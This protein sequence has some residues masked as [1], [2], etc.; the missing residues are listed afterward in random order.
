MAVF[1]VGSML[2]QDPETGCMGIGV[3]LESCKQSF[4]LKQQNQILKQGTQQQS[5]ISSA[6]DQKTKETDTISIGLQKIAE[7]QNQQITE[8]IQNSE[9]SSHKIEILYFMNI[10]LILVLVVVIC[11]FLARKYIKRKI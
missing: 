4:Y 5:V 7:Q 1:N 6:G 11:T 10:C 2:N 8:L 9:Q 3:E